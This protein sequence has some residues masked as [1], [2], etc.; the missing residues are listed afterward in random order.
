MPRHRC[1]RAAGSPCSSAG[2]PRD[3]CARPSRVR[4]ALSHGTGSGPSTCRMPSAGPARVP[5]HG[6]SGRCTAAACRTGLPCEARACCRGVVTG[7]SCSAVWLSAATTTFSASAANAPTA[8]TC[9]VIWATAQPSERRWVA[10]AGSSGGHVA[11]PAPHRQHPSAGPRSTLGCAG[12]IPQGEQKPA[13]CAVQLC[14][15]TVAWMELV[16]ALLQLP[17]L[18]LP[19]HTAAPQP[20]PYAQPCAWCTAARP[21]PPF[22]A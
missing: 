15:P 20:Q 16:P 4:A 8:L 10:V 17:A 12:G 3:R 1:P 7:H 9:A 11:G 14:Q 21:S 13:C 6:C 19:V 2:R 5:R 18:Q 22:P